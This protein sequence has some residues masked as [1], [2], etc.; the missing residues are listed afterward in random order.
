M[1]KGRN[2]A[3]FFHNF[4][5]MF[6][7][8]CSSLYY[9]FVNTLFT[10][11]PTTLFIFCSHLPCNFVNITFAFAPQFHSHFLNKWAVTY[12]YFLNK[13]ATL[14][15]YEQLLICEYSINKIAVMERNFVHISFI[16]RA[17]LCSYFVHNELRLCSYF[18][19]EWA[20]ILLIFCS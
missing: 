19:N 8:L 15:S 11:T 14:Y 10:S 20:A 4:V 7:Y 6:N 16:R 2:F 13:K 17:Q 3:L 1:I 12:S 5:K 9:N 18:I